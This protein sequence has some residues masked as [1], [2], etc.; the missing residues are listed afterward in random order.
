[1]PNNL[2]QI[3]TNSVAGTLITAGS[4]VLSLVTVEDTLKIVALCVTIVAGITTIC[5]NI[6]KIK[7]SN[8]VQ[9]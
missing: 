3:D 2:E 8:D 9:S 4:A 5:Y 1:M 7:K 6:I